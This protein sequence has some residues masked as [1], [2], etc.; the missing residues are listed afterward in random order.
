MR[1]RSGASKDDVAALGQRSTDLRGR[2][3]RVICDLR[4]RAPASFGARPVP[5]GN[6]AGYYTDAKGTSHGYLRS[7]HGT[8]TGFD[9]PGAKSTAPA[10]VNSRCVIGGSYTDAKGIGRGFL[11]LPAGGSA[12][13]ADAGAVCR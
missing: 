7:R 2:A 12:S 13:A 11:R 1:H 10:G 9:V 6:I 8:I 5:A 3:K 4:A